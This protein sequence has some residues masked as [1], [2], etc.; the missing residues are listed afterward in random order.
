[1]IKKTRTAQLRG[2]GKVTY[3]TKFFLEQNCGVV[4]AMKDFGAGLLSCSTKT[5]GTKISE[6]DAVGVIEL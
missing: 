6:R 5:S 4:K 1:V 3:K 2:T